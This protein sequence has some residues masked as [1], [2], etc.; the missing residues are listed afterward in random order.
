MS[1]P[2]TKGRP[3][4][5]DKND[6]TDHQSVALRSC[7]VP[8]LLT[9][10]DGYILEKVKKANRASLLTKFGITQRTFPREQKIQAAE[11]LKGFFVSNEPDITALTQHR[12]VLLQGKLGKVTK[13]LQMQEAIRGL[14]V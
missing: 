6:K 14:S 13:A 5:Y 7:L 2:S 11:A 9:L 12:A 8:A 4:A 1:A 10:V 3:K